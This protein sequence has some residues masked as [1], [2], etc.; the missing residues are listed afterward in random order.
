MKKT[1]VSVF[2]LALLS[3]V[4]AGSEV[5]GSGVVVTQTRQLP[6]FDEIE[7]G[8]PGDVHVTI[9]KPTPLQIEGEDNILP[10]IKTEVRDGRL[11]ISADASFKTKHNTDFRVTV[12]NLKA[13]EIRGSGEMHVGELNNESLGLV[14]KGSGEVHL[15]GKTERLAVRI[16][17]SGD[18]LGS[19]LKAREASVT[20]KGSGDVRVSV[21]DSLDVV[22]HGSG[23]VVYSGNPKL[24][25]TIHG[26][27]DVK[28]SG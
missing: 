28:R 15:D 21:T 8:I 19:S 4:F 23:D 20:I 13:A 25:K 27:G 17:G 10:L 1:L 5:I 26:S 22:I 9:G 24:S 2:V 11:V 18:M 14:I 3:P 6:E 12:A 7:F 16:D